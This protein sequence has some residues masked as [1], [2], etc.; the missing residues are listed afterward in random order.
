MLD[1]EHER[2]VLAWREARIARLTA[3]DGWL[4]LIGKAFLQP[5]VP[6]SV[7]SA[8]D[9]GVQLPGDKAPAALGSVELREGRVH[10]T[11]AAGASMLLSRAGAEPTPLTAARALVSDAAG[12]AD[13]LQYGEITLDVMERASTFA[14]RV[15]DLSRA[16]PEFAGLEYYP[17]DDAWR[18]PARFEPY[19]PERSIELVYDGDLALPFAAPGAL[20]FEKDGVPYRVDPVFESDRK[21]LWLVFADP[22]NRDSTYGAGRFLYAPLPE[23]DRVVLDFNQAFNPPCAFSPFVA[24]PLPPFQNR[25]QLRVEAGEKRPLEH[26]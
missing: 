10:F 1:P 6:L 14:V 13:R 21:R 18:L 3:R 7:G 15:R 5:G 12:R 16:R 11:P 17:I 26:T 22:T 19:T 8:A 4:S 9:S 20:V 23:G 24:C 2:T 25:L